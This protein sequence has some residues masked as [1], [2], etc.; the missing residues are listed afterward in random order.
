MTAHTTA[1]RDLEQ[2]AGSVSASDIGLLIL[3][4]VFGGLLFAHGTQKLFGWF[5][6]MGWD[7]TT[8]SFDQIGYNPGKVFGT[9]AGLC[10]ATGGALLF[11]G[12]LTPLAAAIALGTMINAIN[13][14]WS[15]GLF[16]SQQG[17]GYEIAL[18]FAVVAAALAFTG[19]GRYSLDY[20]RPWE[21]RGV[22]WGVAAVVLAV[23]AAVI[24]LI[25]KWVL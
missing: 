22:T 23:V 11:L 18:L 5:D 2:G 9:L 15:S 17:P 1:A 12:L 24:T 14:T 7:A 19:P 21:R 6:G 10:E 3:R 8:S 13:A 16:G 25:L 4:V 20:G